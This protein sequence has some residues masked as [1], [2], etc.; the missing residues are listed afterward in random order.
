[1]V[2]HIAI[3][4]NIASGKSTVVENLNIFFQQQKI[5]C[6]TFLEPILEWTNFG[7]Q[8]INLLDE[9]YKNPYNNSFLF[10]LGAMLTKCEQL[11]N[12]SSEK[13]VLV[14]R[15]IQAQEMVFIPL[16]NEKQYISN[17]ENEI[18]TR[19]KELLLSWQHLRPTIIIYLNVSPKIAKQR[20]ILRNR[21]EEKD[22]TLNYLERLGQKYDFW[23]KNIPNVIEINADDVSN[24]NSE[25]IYEKIK[26]YF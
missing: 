6:K 21:L 16:L 18:L 23:L 8:N 25:Y 9:M 15:S 2:V 4:G 7:N 12:I 19:Y 26:N 10:Q 11:K 13:I 1:M 24:L 5:V 17:L 20:I 22:I 14:E 3:E